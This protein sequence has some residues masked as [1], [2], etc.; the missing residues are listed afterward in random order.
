MKQPS[1]Q[2]HLLTWVLGTLCLGGPLIV[3]AGYL[4]TLAEIEE[5]L[6]DSLRQTALLLA[7]RDLA[8][9]PTP[10]AERTPDSD[11]DESGLLTVAR[12]PDGTLLFSSRPETPIAFEARPGTSVQRIEGERWH[13]YTVVQH[14]RIIQVAQPE[15][16]RDDAAVETASQMIVPLA[17]LF[18]LITVLMLVALR[19]GLRPLRVAAR[20]LAQ[21][22]AG[23]L[24]P[25]ELRTVPRELLPLVHAFN[26]LLARLGA[27]FAQQRDFVGDAAH[28]L[29]TPV[30]ALQLQLQL[31]QR[32]SDPDEREQAMQELAAGIGRTARLIRQL[33]SLSRAAADEDAGLAFERKRVDLGE[34]ARAAVAR[35]SG[36]AQRRRIDLG[37]E[38]R[39]PGRVWAD[40]SQLETLLD[41]LIENALRY[42]L[43]GGVVDVVAQPLDGA[44]ALRVIDNGPGVAQAESMRVFDRFY[45]SPEA[46]ARDASGSGLGL[47]IV[48]AIADKHGATVS[49]HE[50]HAGIGLEVRVA[51]PASD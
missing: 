22:S 3:L 9:G 8:P 38:V 12:R 19:R 21:R 25:L 32:S 4:I 5:V 50:G 10:A 49:L 2:R 7:D 36:E 39:G 23:S 26:D 18:V 43:A 42:T 46:I 1:I 13:V 44:P 35:W 33:L 6:D 15:A 47:A 27:A 51:F 28:E 14:D 20:D 16:V 41:N 30:T 45:R 11:D 48:K 31:L 17:A 24:D 29:R 37:A 40:A 34:L